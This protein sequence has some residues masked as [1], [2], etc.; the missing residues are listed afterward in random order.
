MPVPTAP[1]G[2]TGHNSSRLIFGAAA[3]GGMKQERADLTIEQVRD[4]GLNHFDT[5]AS[6]GDSELRLAPF[7]SEHRSDVFLATK[8]DQRTGADAR[9]QLEASL[10][11]MGVDQVDL[12]QLHNLTQE[13]DWNQAF[14]DDGAVAA[15]VKAK[16]E[17]L[18]RFIGVTGH[19]TY[20]PEMHLRSLAAFPF[21][22]VLVPV[23]YSMS[24]NPQYQADV[25]KLIDTCR[26]RG[27]AIQ[28]IKAIAMRRWYEGEEARRFSW[29]RAVTDRDVMTRLIR[30]VLSQPNLFL[31]TTSDARLLET[32]IEIGMGDLS[33]PDLEQLASDYDEQGM[34]PLF[35]RDVS[36]QVMPLFGKRPA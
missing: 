5:A 2:S 14:A 3:L 29:Y 28:T 23:S 6:Y 33:A 25:G 15:L 10:E 13:P 30:F 16:E 24:R 11:R 17:G 31:N 32:I 12:I 34:A 35:E 4:A 22:S 36:D 19:G 8:T 21:D 1:F 18:T 26:E 9:R 27:V 20:C 7:L